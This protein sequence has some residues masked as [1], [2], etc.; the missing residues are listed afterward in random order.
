V[1]DHADSPDQS[2]CCKA[3]GDNGAR[4]GEFVSL[5]EIDAVS[6]DTID[7]FKRYPFFIGAKSNR[8][9]DVDATSERQGSLPLEPNPE[10]GKRRSM[11]C[12]A[13]K[14]PA[15]F[16]TQRSA[17]RSDLL[18]EFTRP[19]QPGYRLGL[20]AL[21]NATGRHHECQATDSGQFSPAN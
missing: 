4:V 12:R 6:R 13:A 21:G 1:D 3:S 5:A 11:G 15:G 18:N 9:A 8:H 2:L 7:M 10:H 16:H 14:A 20:L 19:T 17:K